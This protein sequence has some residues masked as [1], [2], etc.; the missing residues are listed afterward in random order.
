M[1]APTVR[2][3]QRFPVH[4]DLLDGTVTSI[5]NAN[6]SLKWESSSRKLRDSTAARRCTGFRPRSNSG[7]LV[8][9]SEGTGR[10]RCRETPP[11]L[12]VTRAGVQLFILPVPGAWVHQ[13]PRPSRLAGNPVKLGLNFLTKVFAR[14]CLGG[15][16][17]KPEQVLL[18]ELPRVSMLARFNHDNFIGTIT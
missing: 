5:E 1:L 4:A 3:I 15:G 6:L 10:A 9:S 7:T 18:Q 16:D 8:D 17:T 12:V 11:A 13:S 14:P 2:T